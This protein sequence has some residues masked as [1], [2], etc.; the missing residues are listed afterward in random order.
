MRLISATA[1]LLALA[2]C[3]QGTPPE[4][5]VEV[6]G[7]IVMLPPIPGRPGAAY[8]TLASNNEPTKLVAVTSPPIERIE[9]HGTA[10]DGGVTRMRPLPPDALVFPGDLKMT[11]A[12][13]ERHAMLFGI[14]P[15]L[16]PG[17]R[18]TLT[19]ELEPLGPAS[20]DAE[21]RAFGQSHGAH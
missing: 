4:P 7:A 9:L 20:V 12:P 15:A 16:K 1:A 6:E 17:D 14:D 13:G 10:Q 3:N 2:A 8:F 18:V 11:F 21:V 19:F 5:A